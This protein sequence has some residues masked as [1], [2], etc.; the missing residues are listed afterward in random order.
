MKARTISP[1]HTVSLA[2]GGVITHEY[3]EQPEEA[4]PELERHVALGT[5]EMDDGKVEKSKGLE[6]EN[7]KHRDAMAAITASGKTGAD[8]LADVQRENARH[9]SALAVLAKADAAAKTEADAA[10]KR[11]AEVKAAADAKKKP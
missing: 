8:R 6:A 2:K 7:T 4:R 11:D 3:S 10:A 1:D 9:D 5:V